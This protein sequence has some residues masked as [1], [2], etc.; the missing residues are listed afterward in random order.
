MS[1]YLF[2]IDGSVEKVNK[3]IIKVNFRPLQSALSDKKY[4]KHQIFLLLEYLEGKLMSKDRRRYG[5]T[6]LMN[7]ITPNT[8]SHSRC[9]QTSILNDHISQQFSISL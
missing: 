7:I 8:I 6:V 2:S 3:R 5:Y 4:I 1:N 9:L